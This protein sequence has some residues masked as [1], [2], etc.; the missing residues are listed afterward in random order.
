MT[1]IDTG[2][3]WHPAV[4]IHGR[5]R[6][7]AQKDATLPKDPTR[8]T[9]ATLGVEAPARLVPRPGARNLVQ[10]ERVPQGRFLRSQAGGARGPGVCKRRAGQE[11]IGM[12][13]MNQSL[14]TLVKLR[15]ISMDAAVAVSSM[16]DELR[17]LV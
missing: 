4:V 10:R 16:P 1:N 6:N 13:T 17:D 14:A 8:N 3:K 7:C 15:R 11:K 5:Q 2:D 9:L 12:Q